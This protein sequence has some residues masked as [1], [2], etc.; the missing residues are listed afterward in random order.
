MNIR[1]TT[2]IHSRVEPKQLQLWRDCW[3]K[4][5]SVQKVQ[6]THPNNK[7]GCWADRARNVTHG[8]QLLKFYC[9]GAFSGVQ[10]HCLLLKL[11]SL[12]T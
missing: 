1:I 12:L 2:F 4:L 11:L 8:E 7:T 6:H 3:F 10:T 9:V 5:H